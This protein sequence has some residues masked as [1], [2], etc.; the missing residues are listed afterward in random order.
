MP[1]FEA[2]RLGTISD[3]HKQSL[4]TD[5]TRELRFGIRARYPIGGFRLLRKT[6]AAARFAPRLTFDFV[7]L[8]SIDGLPTP[9]AG[10]LPHLL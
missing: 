1:H 9:Y 6:T 7:D 3:R 2:L 8:P 10:R 4:K 5:L